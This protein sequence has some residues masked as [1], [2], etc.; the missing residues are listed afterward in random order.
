[1]WPAASNFCPRVHVC[2]G[3]F[4][5]FFADEKCIPPVP[6]QPTQRPAFLSVI[7]ARPCSQSGLSAIAARKCH[8]E[9]LMWKMGLC[10]P[11]STPNHLEQIAAHCSDSLDDWPF[12]VRYICAGADGGRVV[13][14]VFAHFHRR[15]QEEGWLARWEEIYPMR[16]MRA[17]RWR[18][19]TR[20][21]RR[22][23]VLTCWPLSCSQ[24]GG[25]Q[26]PTTRTSLAWEWKDWVFVRLRSGQKGRKSN[27]ALTHK[28][29]FIEGANIM[30]QWWIRQQP[31]RPPFR[32]KRGGMNRNVDTRRRGVTSFCQ[33]WLRRERWSRTKQQNQLF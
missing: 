6:Q 33:R 11:W 30:Q 25:L 14:T 18:W 27:T 32:K 21:I 12:L 4:C 9:R 19:K 29:K 5:F 13:K 2:F 1:M 23:T 17:R 28:K 16:E 22:S 24:Q 15:R 20:I 10:L 3:V 31:R 8:A 26:S 7:S